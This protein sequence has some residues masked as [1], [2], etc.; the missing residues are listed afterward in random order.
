[1]NDCHKNRTLAKRHSQIR[2]SDK[3]NSEIELNLEESHGS[4]NKIFIGR[5]TFLHP[6]LKYNHDYNLLLYLGAGMLVCGF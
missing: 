2:G 3:L 6:N 4:K 1:M 5:N